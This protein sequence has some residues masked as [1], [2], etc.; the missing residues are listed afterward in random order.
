MAKNPFFIYTMTSNFI[1]I[2]I[3]FLLIK[4]IALQMQILRVG[5]WL[6]WLSGWP[7]LVGK[8]QR[9]KPSLHQEG[10]GLLILSGPILLL[11]RKQNGDSVSIRYSCKIWDIQIKKASILEVA[12]KPHPWKCLMGHPLW[13]WSKTNRI[14][15]TPPSRP[16]RNKPKN[17]IIN[18]LCHG[19]WSFV[20]CF[21]GLNP[22]R[23]IENWKIWAKWVKLGQFWQD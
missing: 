5:L 10:T 11:K 23:Q 3:M 13:V 20:P 21:F 6:A 8:S 14:G 1:C 22:F 2:K 18:K 16:N 9:Q 19:P 15:N 4:Y 7:I 17:F 12:L